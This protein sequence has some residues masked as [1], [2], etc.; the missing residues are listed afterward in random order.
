MRSSPLP[1]ETSFEAKPF[2]LFANCFFSWMRR[3]VFLRIASIGIKG[4]T[5][6]RNEWISPIRF[7]PTRNRVRSVS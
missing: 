5:S 7:E 1:I 4:D 6:F 2:S 3:T